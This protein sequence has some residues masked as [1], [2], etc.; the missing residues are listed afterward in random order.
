MTLQISLAGRGDGGAGANHV[1]GVEM[2]VHQVDGG[3]ERLE[4]V[5][6]GG[7]FPAAGT[8]NIVEVG[9]SGGQVGGIDAVTNGSDGH[10][11]RGGRDVGEVLVVLDMDDVVDL[12]GGRFGGRVDGELV[13]DVLKRRGLGLVVIG[14]YVMGVEEKYLGHGGDDADTAGSGV[15]E[16]I[17]TVLAEVGIAAERFITCRAQHIETRAL[18]R[19]GCGDVLENELLVA[20]TVI[21]VE[22][23]SRLVV[24]HVEIQLVVRHRDA[25]NGLAARIDHV[26]DHGGVDVDLSVPVDGFI[27][28]TARDDSRQRAH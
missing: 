6:V 10:R 12:D 20:L 11:H 28:V 21:V 24:V 5:F 16:A 17:G 19:F 18:G 1:V 4:R 9:G 13:H 15:T 25:D 26:V 23:D 22:L 14:H 3:V 27:I 7:A 2:V 8:V